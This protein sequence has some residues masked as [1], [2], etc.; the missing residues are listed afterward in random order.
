MRQLGENPDGRLPGSGADS[1]RRADGYRYLHVE[2]DAREYSVDPSVLAHP[3]N[4]L[5]KIHK[6]NAGLSEEQD[7]QQ[8]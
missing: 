2:E 4:G 5:P 6:G 8:G 3:P 1:P 7:Y